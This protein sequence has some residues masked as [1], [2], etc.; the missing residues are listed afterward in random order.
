LTS[1]R[2]VFQ[3]EKPLSI[4]NSHQ[5]LI[6]NTLPHSVFYNSNLNNS[7]EKLFLLLL[8]LLGTSLLLQGV[9]AHPG[10][11]DGEIEPADEGP[12]TP[13]TPT[14]SI[15]PTKPTTPAAPVRCEIGYYDVPKAPF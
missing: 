9:Q 7:N 4:F 6:V 10:H 11:D 3:Q 2:P 13:V 1:K 5:P 14:K 8:C 15:T 12:S